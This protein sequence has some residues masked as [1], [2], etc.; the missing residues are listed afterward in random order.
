MFFPFVKKLSDVNMK[1]LAEAGGKNASLG[2]MI[3]SL[4]KRGVS[5]PG[6]FI[7]TASAYRH[8]I[9][10]SGLDVFIKDALKNLDTKNLKQLA[11]TGKRIRGEITGSPF[12]KDLE[13]AIAKIHAETEKIYGRDAD[14][15]VRSSA[16]AEDLPGASFAGEHETYLNIRGIED[17]LKASK[18]AMAS[19]FNDRAISYRE[20]KGFD[21]FKIALSVGV[22]KMVRSDLASSG[23]MFTLDTE[24]GFPNVIIINATRGLGEMIVQGQVTPDEF[25]IFKP[26]LGKKSERNILKKVFSKNI[27][28]PLISKKLGVKTRKMIYS[29]GI[30]PTEIIRTSNSER[31][32]FSISDQEVFELAAWG[33]EIE[34]HYTRLHG[35]WTPMDIEWAKD[36]RDGKLYIVQARPETIH[37]EKDNTKIKEYQLKDKGI[38]ITKGAS[39]GNAIASGKARIIISASQ[40]SEFKAGEILVTEVTDPNWEPIMKIASA[41]VTDKGGRTSHAAIVSRE[42]SIPCVVGTENST[43][44]IKSGDEI[45]VD[46]AG[47]EG[48]VYKGLLKFN[49]NEISTKNLPKTKT[50]IMI[51]IATP[52]TAFGKSFLPNSGVGLAREEFIIADYIGIHPNTLINYAKLEGDLKKQVDKKTAGYKDKHGSST[53]KKQYYID[54]LSYGIAKISAS[55]YPHPV[56]VRLSDFKTN[57]YRSLL[58]GDLYEPVEENPMIGWRGA[59]RYYSPDFKEAFLLEVE[60]LKKVRNEYGLTNTIV[61]VPFCRTVEEGSKVIGL[62]ESNGLSRTKDKSLKFYVMCEIPSNVL[63]ASEFLDIFDGMSIGSNDLTQLVL[64]IDRDGNDKIHSIANENSEAVKKMISA[65]IKVCRKRHKY[66]GICGQAPSDYPEFAAFLVKE[67][68]QSIS[69]NPD[70]IIGAIKRIHK[71]EQAI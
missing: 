71:E 46:T 9:K 42:L 17:V 13:E 68:I 22:Q 63:L 50:E 67:G 52:D 57:E 43:K 28:H 48:I 20:D 59:S 45:T 27:Y 3:S 62:M 61:M 69:L 38:Q 44:L 7:I 53:R 54:N 24:T 18:K 36:G 30:N 56:I 35:K 49:V 8:F 39:V 2:E 11:D 65:V 66:I 64:G 6:G 1:D 58:G 70:S 34:K 25:L 10:F 60:A 23:I 29:D 12:P 26:T 37:S 47:A 51:N 32:K 14:F 4:G 33:M 19:L 16:T 5:V 41:I 55:F 15:A 21:H 31:E 40:I